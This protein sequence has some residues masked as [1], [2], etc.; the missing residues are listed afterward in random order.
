MEGTL[1]RTVLEEVGRG[2]LNE[3]Q[4]RLGMEG[5]FEWRQRCRAGS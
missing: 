3:E 1:T 4:E 2:A 5:C